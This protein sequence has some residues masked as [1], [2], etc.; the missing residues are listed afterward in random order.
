MP[1][2][3]IRFAEVLLN[4]AEAA[5]AI[6]N[7]SEAIQVLKD[8]RAR[9][10]YSVAVSGADYGL[11]V[12]AL[13]DRGKLFGA[14]LYERQIEL[15][16]EG[17]RFDDMRRWLLW[18]GG[19]YFNQVD[20]A[21]SSWTLSGF[22]GNT[23]TYLGVEPLNGKRRDN[24][25]LRTIVTAAETSNSDPI[26]AVRPVPIDLKN[27]VSTQF[28]GLA[29]FYDTHL[30]RKTRKGDEAGK[31]ITFQPKYYFIGLTSSAQT[32]NIT[33]QQTIGWADVARGSV[34]GTFDPLAE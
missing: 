13:A 12:A 9:A 28:S 21:P 26:K 31:V 1:H 22:G 24:I 17:K 18:D 19:V 2:M 32:N 15:A 20:G 14:I 27:D 7:T 34:N 10:G 16:Y 29:S 5:C 30:V 25:E 11:D 4:F 6:G 23:C 8:I 33:L 3:E